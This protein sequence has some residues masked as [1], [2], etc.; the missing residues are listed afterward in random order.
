MMGFSAH[1]AVGVDVRARLD[2]RERLE[3][4]AADERG[5]DAGSERGLLVDPEGGVARAVAL[6]AS[7]GVRS[8]RL[9]PWESGY[10]WGVLGCAHA[11]RRGVLLAV[12]GDARRL[13]PGVEGL[14]QRPLHLPLF[15]GLWVAARRRLGGLLP[16]EQQEQRNGAEQQQ[17][18]TAEGQPGSAGLRAA[19]GRV[20]RAVE[21]RAAAAAHPHAPPAPPAAVGRPLRLAVGRRIGRGPMPHAAR[22]PAGMDLVI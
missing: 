16:D 8:E 5:V 21:A 7:T 3:V 17:R 6:G 2:R 18:G 9:W 12:L 15:A 11:Q 20:R 19:A 22:R 10:V 14:L 1:R 4:E 13:Q